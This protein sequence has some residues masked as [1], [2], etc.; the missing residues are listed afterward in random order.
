MR[1]DVGYFDLNSAAEMNTRLFDDIKKV[2]DGIGDKLGLAVQ[3]VAQTIGGIV[4]GF[5]YGWKMSLVV[6]ACTPAIAVTGYVFFVVTTKFSK[7][8]LD[9]YAKAGDVAEEVLS[10]IRTVTAFGGQEMVTKL[11]KLFSS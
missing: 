4:I 8:E 7:S 5:I 11:P 10:S 2:S 3:A 6:L 1:Q 9:S